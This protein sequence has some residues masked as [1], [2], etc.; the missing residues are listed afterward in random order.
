VDLNRDGTE[1]SRWEGSAGSFFKWMV[2]MS[3]RGWRRRVKAGGR[4]V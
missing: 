3:A 4:V 1:V 2:K